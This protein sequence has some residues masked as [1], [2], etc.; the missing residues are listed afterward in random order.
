MQ[1]ARRGTMD[2]STEQPPHRVVLEALAHLLAVRRQHQ[3]VAHLRTHAR[4]ARSA[5]NAVSPTLLPLVHT[6][7]TAAWLRA[8]AA[9]GAAEPASH[10]VLEG[11]LVEERRGQHHERV[12][13]AGGKRRREDG[14]TK[15]GAVWH[16]CAQ[17]A[18][19]AVRRSRRPRTSVGGRCGA[20]VDACGGVVR[21][22]E[23]EI[24]VCVRSRERAQAQQQLS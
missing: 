12:E 22:G 14:G 23:V 15:V 7:P 17:R 19:R 5:P 9:R 8:T 13:P 24:D 11:R 20:A 4:S 10:Q 6:A 16:R 18:T 1:T 3:A 2:G 21:G